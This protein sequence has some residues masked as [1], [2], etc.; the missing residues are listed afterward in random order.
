VPFDPRLT[1]TIA[2]IGSTHKGESDNAVALATTML[3]KAGM[4]WRDIAEAVGEHAQLIKERDKLLAA[5]ITLKAERDAALCELERLRKQNGGSLAGAFWVDTR[6]PAI[7]ANRHARWALDTADRHGIQLTIKERDFLDGCTRRG[8][9]SER[10]QDWLRDL[11]A[12]IAQRSGE[13][14]PP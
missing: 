2:M 6:A 11:A 10:Q 8:R 9:L 4:N 12:R 5:G 7:P 13:M 3:T 14:P 1:A